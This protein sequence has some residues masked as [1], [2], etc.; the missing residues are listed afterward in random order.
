MIPTFEEQQIREAVSPILA[1][2][3]IRR[4]F[5]ADGRG[6]T[7]VPAVI[8]LAIPG[9]DGEF[10]VKTAY[11]AGM[12]H[13]AVKV[14]SGFYDNPT[15][16]LP[17]GTGLMM[18]FDAAT[19]MPAALLLDNGYLTDVRTGAAGAVAADSLARR[20]IRTVGII[21]SGVQAR[22]QAICLH[23]V[24]R[25]DRLIAWSID[26]TGLARY[27]EEMR[28]RLGIEATAARTAEAV[29]READLLVTCTPS[30]KP[31][32][33][34]AWL[35]AGVHITALG[36]D[37]PGKQELDPRCLARADV[38]VCDRVS[39]CRRLGE[40]QHA[41]ASGLLHEEDVDAELGQLVAGVKGGRADEAQ[42]T[43]ADLTGV[44][45]QDTAIASLAF[46]RLVRA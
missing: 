10:H 39:Q 17:T 44:G 11:V 34:A 24:R 45:F 19:G 16:G 12:S 15:R 35:H 31:I 5:A 13:V 7:V 23:Q 30:R 26:H 9:V 18:L 2:D 32:V 46:E 36:S 14:A 6:E 20:D 38:V 42:I 43:I 28:E 3:V 41:L 40:L 22:Q 25:F 37:G 29:V 27:V 1:I 21:G 33:D 8:N 4:A